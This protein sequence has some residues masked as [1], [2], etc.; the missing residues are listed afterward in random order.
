MSYPGRLLRVKFCHSSS[1]SVECP[2]VLNAQ[3]LCSSDSSLEKQTTPRSQGQLLPQCP[4]LQI[5]LLPLAQQAAQE[6]FRDFPALPR[7][8]TE[9]KKENWL[10]R[11][12]HTSVSTSRQF[13]SHILALLY[14]AF[15]ADKIH[16][17]ILQLKPRLIDIEILMKLLLSS[18]IFPTSV[19]VS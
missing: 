18:F 11:L 5:S 15:P 4:G 9:R 8:H 16:S 13:N 1:F 7:H 10:C 6:V 12:S 2:S 14:K 19:A 17:V 3:G